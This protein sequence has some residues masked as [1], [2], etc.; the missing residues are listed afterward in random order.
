MIQTPKG[1]VLLKTIDEL[2][3]PIGM[4]SLFKVFFNPPDVDRILQIPLNENLSEDF[5]GWHM[6]NSYSF[7]VR[8]A[9]YVQWN[10]IHNRG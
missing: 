2:I 4:M 5:I 10:H 9:Y 1:Q 3:D 7:L 6:T 8:S